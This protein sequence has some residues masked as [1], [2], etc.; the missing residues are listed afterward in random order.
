MDKLE[1]NNN[2]NIRVNLLVWFGLTLLIAIFGIVN[3]WPSYS[4]VKFSSVV[5]GHISQKLPQEHQSFYFVYKVMGKIYSS[6]GR[7]D[8]DFSEIQV[9][10][11]ITVYYDKHHPENCTLDQPKV[12]LI[13]TVGGVV[14]QC[15][16]IPLISMII[17]HRFQILPKWNL[18]DKVRL[19]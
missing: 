7:I 6:S 15:A 13:R 3:E 4:L 17:L 2:S 19:G 9:G 11:P 14:A 12:D 16:I 1:D 18:F 5:Q 10:D 8:R